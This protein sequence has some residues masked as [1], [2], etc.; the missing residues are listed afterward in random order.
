MINHLK[1]KFIEM[2]IRKLEI[3][4]YKIFDDV[5][6][7][8]TDNNGNTLDT[9]VLAGLNGTGKT[10]ILELINDLFCGNSTEGATDKTQIKVELDF[11]INNFFK[12]LLEKMSF[13]NTDS[14]DYN[15][16]N[17]ADFVSTFSAKNNILTIKYQHKNAKT[18]TI[19]DFKKLAK[20]FNETIK[21]IH[22]NIK[23]VYRYS[24]DKVKSNPKNKEFSGFF[25]EVS[26]H[27]HKGDMK[28]QILEP[29][30][31]QFFSDLDTPRKKI[32]D[33]K[34]KQLNQ[35]FKNLEI[36]TKLISI[37][38]K[39]L[40]FRSKNGRKVYFE[41]LSS[42]EKQVSFAGL[43]FSILETE[44]SVLLIDEPEDSLHP[45]W[46]NK[47]LGFYQNIGKNTQLIVATHSP[48]IIASAK[49]ENVF[50]LK[51]EANK[52]EIKQP[53]YSKG[54]SIPYVL[55]EIMETSYQDSYINNIVNQYL[56]L[57][58]NGKHKS[59]KGQK[60]YDI[61]STLSPESEEK[62]KVDFSL[63]RFNAIG[64]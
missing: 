19:T 23:G 34:I 36:N 8:F 27:T 47:I 33:N 14:S 56:E 37:D 12:L 41:D 28:E 48:Q 29:I 63:K 15:D 20:I 35:A 7:D 18:K 32:I 59:E 4:N 60:L 62:V 1:S 25:Q 39:E 49:P 13:P 38:S 22:D 58:R 57:I 42:G 54:H 10:T 21:N 30:T 11:S 31:K 51:F 55:S 50:L 16:I 2:K 64:K 53:K 40:L 6:F 61:I 24:N 3:K 45:S 5:K 26:F 46:Q 9:I 44:N 43:Y 17:L 52:V